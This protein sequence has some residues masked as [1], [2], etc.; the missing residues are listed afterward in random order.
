MVRFFALLR[1]VE[2][3]C[4]EAVRDFVVAQVF[5]LL[6]D[7]VTRK[8]LVLSP[9]TFVLTEAFVADIFTGARS[10]DKG[11]KLIFVDVLFQNGQV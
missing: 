6:A 9:G 7:L 10:S 8:H 11:R 2:H 5:G 4:L 3:I 1:A